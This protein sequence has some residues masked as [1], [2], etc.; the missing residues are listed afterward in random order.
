MLNEFAYWKRRYSSNTDHY[1]SK[2]L[3]VTRSLESVRLAKEEERAGS[4]TSSEV[5]DAELDL[6]R[7]KAGVVNA[8]VN[9]VESLINLELALGR[10][11]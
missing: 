5:L 6:F 10:T 4:R 3:N 8:Q 2:Q 1:V 7:S 11:I 9:A